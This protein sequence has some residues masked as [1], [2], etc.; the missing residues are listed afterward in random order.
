VCKL[1]LAVYSQ[2]A[3]CAEPAHLTARIVCAAG[4]VCACRCKPGFGSLTGQ[5]SCKLCPINTW[6][7]GGSMEECRPCPFGTSSRPGSTSESQC[8]SVDSC[9]PGSEVHK[10]L[11]SPAS[12]ADCV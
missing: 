10:A 8:Y 7:A 2:Q 9:P 1:L 11:A 6:S 4:F 5:G 12:S 3:V